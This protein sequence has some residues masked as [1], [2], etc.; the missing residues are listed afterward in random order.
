[1]DVLSDILGG[2]RLDSALFA[3]TELRSPW[4]IRAEGRPHVAFHILLR[5]SCWLE[6]DGRD[7]AQASVGDVILIAPG[8]G[9]TLR[10]ARS[11]EARSFQ[12]LA[13]A[14]AFARPEGADPRPPGSTH[15]VCGRFEFGDAAA[16]TLVSVLPPVIHLGEMSHVGPWLEHT[17]K[18]IGYE[19]SGDQPGNDVIVNRLC[20]ALF[21]YVV[22][23]VVAQGGGQHASWLRGLSDPR[24]CA[25]MHGIHEAPAH[26]WTVADLARRATMSRSAF[27]ARF[28]ELVGD[29]PM[30]YLAAW[31]LQKAATRLR[32]SDAAIAEIAA[33]VGYDSEPAFHKAF[34]RHVG[35]TPGAYRKGA[36]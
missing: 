20:D 8:L 33:A 7:A 14:G 29:T 36:A 10:D 19:S 13:V 27:S 26:P 34:K 23:A 24:I 1:L 21:V 4:G 16:K 28:V 9:H 11:S 31:R 6:V 22:R 5:G 30:H 3:H 12:E 15:L 25:A 2:L 18:L 32:D 17:L 35:V